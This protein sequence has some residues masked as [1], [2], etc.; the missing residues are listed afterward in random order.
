MT[1]CGAGQGE[2]SI[3]GQFCADRGHIPLH[4]N[5]GIILTLTRNYDSL[6]IHSRLT[7]ILV[8]MQFRVH[9]FTYGEMRFS[10]YVHQHILHDVFVLMV[11]IARVFPD[12]LKVFIW[13]NSFENLS[14]FSVDEKYTVK[15]F[16]QMHEIHCTNTSK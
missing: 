13:K 11:E 10:V 7:K 1:S 4:R 9:S 8:S 15:Y 14:L 3:R 12:L 16:E 6:S 2:F 5:A